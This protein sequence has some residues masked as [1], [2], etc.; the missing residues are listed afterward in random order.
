MQKQHQYIERAS[1]RVCNEYPFADRLVRWMYHPVREHARGLFNTLVGARMSH[2]LG[3]I[4]YD[5]DLPLW[6]SFN[7][8]RHMSF[9]QQ[10]GVREE[11]CVVPLKMLDTP[12]KIFERKI[13]Y[14]DYRPMEND[15]S[16]VAAPA[17][18]RMLCGSLQT[19]S[20]LFL[21][22]KF[23]DL[24]ELVDTPT[25]Q[26]SERFATGDYAVF[27]LT[28]DKYH[29]NH[30]PVSGII[31]AQYE[32]DGNYHACNPSA[33]VAEVTPYSKNRRLVTII[34]TDIEGGSKVGTVAMVEVV[35]LMIGAL[36]SCYTG[37]SGYEPVQ[38]Q[39]QGLMLHKGQPKSLFRPGSSTVVLLFEPGRIRFCPDLLSNQVRLDVSSRFS[40]GF[41]ASLVETEVLVR[42]TIATANY[43]THDG[44][45]SAGVA[46]T[47]DPGASL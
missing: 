27:R 2:W 21:K 34:D 20:M 25:M 35:A 32:I 28:P 29:Y 7:R 23:F 12:R 38:D 36:K 44:R 39:H 31:A 47:E 22:D 37:G 33:V 1:A 30:V 16:A 43:S 46:S 5:L 19:E 9:L 6:S 4:N 18:S 15:P 41:G 14:R 11:E 24:A 13:R 17:D 42:S 26:Y 3:Y 40:S 10:C 45:P 8:N